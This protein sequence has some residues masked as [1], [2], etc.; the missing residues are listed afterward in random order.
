MEIGAEPC[1]WNDDAAEVSAQV[2]A[3]DGGFHA[4]HYISELLVVADLAAANKPALPIVEPFAG[5]EADIGPVNLT[6]GPTCIDANVEASPAQSW[7]DRISSPRLIT[8]GECRSGAEPDGQSD[9]CT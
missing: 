1:G 4:Q 9:G 3:A 8:I 2:A 5:G 6:P 7:R